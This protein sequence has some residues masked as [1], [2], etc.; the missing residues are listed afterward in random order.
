MT[1]Y[2][3][4]F[5]P[6]EVPT[7]FT[8]NGDGNNDILNVLARE[9]IEVDILTFRIFDRWG[10]LVFE[11]KDIQPNQPSEG[12]DGDYRGALAQ[13]GVYLWVVEVEYADG[14]TEVFKGQ[15]TLIR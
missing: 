5:R 8:P 3:R 10:E 6:V 2:A 4:K 14:L 13:P 9:D 12:W 1:L 7:G 15:T 11:R